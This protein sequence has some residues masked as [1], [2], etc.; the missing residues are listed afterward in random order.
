MRCRPRKK[1]PSA[2]VTLCR[3]ILILMLTGSAALTATAA[4]W[5]SRPIRFVV[6]F[7][8][9][10]SNRMAAPGVGDF[11]SRSFGQRI[12]GENKAGATRNARVVYAQIKLPD[13]DHTA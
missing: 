10:G 1:E 3:F 2:M 11:L 7:P 13:S 12:A 4:E 9:G 8:A 6:P 5:P